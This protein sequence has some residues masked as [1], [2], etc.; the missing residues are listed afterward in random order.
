MSWKRLTSRM[1][2]DNPWITVYDETVTNP[3]GG[4]NLYGRVHF[5][6]KAVAIVPLDKD[7]NTWLV[8]QHRYTTDEYTWEVPMGG[9][10]PGEDPMETAIR[11]LKEETGLTA[12]VM[13]PLMRLHTSNSITD[14]EGFIFVAT[15]LTLGETDF[16]EMEDLAIRKLPLAEALDMVKSNEITDAISIIALLRM[17]P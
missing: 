6:S 5:K 1:V 12:G 11:E 13:K 4:E 10:D 16:D 9:S 2:Y 3:A 15:E 17:A 8:G 7:G 14:E